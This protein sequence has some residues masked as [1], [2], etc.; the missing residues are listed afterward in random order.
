[1]NAPSSKDH[2]NAVAE[3]HAT[4]WFDAS[5]IDGCPWSDTA[6]ARWVRSY[7]E[8]FVKKGA[9]RLIRNVV[10]T[11]LLL[12]V[13][14]VFLPVTVN[15]GGEDTCYVC[16]PLA[17]YV[18]Y[19]IEELREL[20]SPPLERLL[21]WVLRA[22][23]WFLRWGD[24]DRV[25][26]VNN[27]LLST[28]L[29]P[30]LSASQV[31]SVVDAARARF[32]DHAVVF[33]SLNPTTCA[34][35]MSHLRA[36]G[37]A[38]VASRQVYVFPDLDERSLTRDEQRELR[39]DRA[40]WD[41][42]DYSIRPGEPFTAEELDRGIDLYGQLYLEKYS[43]LNPQFTVEWLKDVSASG[44]MGVFG[45]SRAGH[46]DGIVGYFQVEGVLTTPLFGY[47]MAIPRERGLYRMLSSLTLATAFDA[48]C[49]DHASSGVAS[50]KQNRGYRS[51]IEYSAVLTSHL[52][53]RRRVVWRV[54]HALM[55]NVAV[56]LLRKHKL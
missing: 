37:A 17:H 9:S 48:S 42:S 38:F 22:L 26:H 43:T 18:T 45:I 23:G 6:H 5:T 39:R 31:R 2:G 56:P 55:E 12:Q 3:A 41:R 40:L 47:D 28:N 51:A 30:R 11:P 27:A 34:A 25:L 4:R 20:R 54:L 49:L 29:Y 50:F 1:M 14:D 52:G 36:V 19:A 32:P 35:W 8:P 7:W 10:T 21:A 53:W 33:R 46:M 13:D 24:V 16:S 15:P 44:A